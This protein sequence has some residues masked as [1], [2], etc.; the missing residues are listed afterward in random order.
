MSDTGMYKNLSDKEYAD[1]ISK[2]D[3]TDLELCALFY[4]YRHIPEFRAAFKK[5]YEKRSG[6]SFNI[7]SELRILDLIKDDHIASAILFDKDLD[8][9][10]KLCDEYDELG[11][12]S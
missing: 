11:I 2:H 6:H 7:R 9:A 1:Y 8:K 4:E 12:K 10:Y 5:E 3:L